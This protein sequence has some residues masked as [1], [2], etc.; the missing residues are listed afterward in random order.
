MLPFITAE[1]LPQFVINSCINLVSICLKYC[2]MPVSQLQLFEQFLTNYFPQ[3]EFN[4]LF[5]NC[6]DSQVVIVQPANNFIPTSFTNRVSILISLIENISLSTTYS[7]Y[8][9]YRKNMYTFK[10]NYLAVILQLTVW[11]LKV[12]TER[13]VQPPENNP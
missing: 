6:L 4:V 7:S 5:L 10:N 3:F 9:D 2:L 12:L 1:Q 8:Y 11:Y 13:T